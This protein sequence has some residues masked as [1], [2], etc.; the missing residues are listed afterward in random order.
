LE[1]LPMKPPITRHRNTTTRYIQTAADQ[2]LLDQMDEL[3]GHAARGDQR[4]IGAIAVAFGSTLAREARKELSPLYELDAPDVVERFLWDLLQEKLS[5]PHIRGAAVAW[6]KRMVREG[7]RR[8]LAKRG[9]GW[10]E[11]G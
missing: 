9:G 2:E 4:A 1:I 7:A 8:H 3:V 11:A 5:F 10:K 6:M